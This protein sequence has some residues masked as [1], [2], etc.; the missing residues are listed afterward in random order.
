MSVLNVT[1]EALMSTPF[2]RRRMLAGMAGLPALALVGC[3]FDRTTANPISTVNMLDFGNRLRIPGLAASRVA[4]DGVREF[5][6]SVVAA[7]A[8]FLAGTS[9][10]TWGYTDGGN[11]AGYLGPTLSAARGERVRVT[12]EN[13]LSETTSVHWHGMH[14]PARFDGGPHQ[15]IGAGE[16]WQPEWLI[17][18]P[19]ATL[20]YHPTARRDGVSGHSRAGRAVLPRR[21]DEPGSAASLWDRRHPDHPPGPQLRLARAVLTARPRGDGPARRQDSGERHLQSVP[22]GHHPPGPAA[23]PERLNRADLPFGLRG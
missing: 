17:D 9:T 2:S 11:D 14:L 3:G 18:Q 13:R 5:R 10:P 23:D 15:P 16:S 8:E 7:A 20:W 12:V 1:T 22:S 6:L 21:R 4:E 19:A